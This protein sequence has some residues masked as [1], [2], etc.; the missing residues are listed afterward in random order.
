METVQDIAWIALLLSGVV[1]VVVVI[2]VLLRLRN[3]IDVLL[4]EIQRFG[5]RTEPILDKLEA[6][7]TKTE[8][9][10]TMITENREALRQATDNLRTVTANIRRLETALQEQIEPVVMGV[11]SRLAGVRNG[12][13]A[14]LDTLRKRR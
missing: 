5:Q 7:A 14:F 6:V 3:S 8:E 1:L 13:A 2:T 10:L 12:I 9:A 11:A 4:Q